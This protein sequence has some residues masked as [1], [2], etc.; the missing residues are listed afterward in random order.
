VN[1]V[2]DLTDAN[3]FLGDNALS[4]NT[5]GFNNTMIGSSA[6]ASN[7]TGATNTATGQAALASNTIGFN[8]TADG[9]GALAPTKLK[10]AKATSK[11]AAHHTW[12]IFAKPPTVIETYSQRC[13]ND[14]YHKIIVCSHWSS[15]RVG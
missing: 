8:N 14:I 4:V 13:W 1:R 7:S 5:D 15:E 6:L 2:C 11:S 3:T 9:A 12:A 10:H